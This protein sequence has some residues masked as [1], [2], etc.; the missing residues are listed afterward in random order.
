ML[1]WKADKPGA[2]LT[3]CHIGW[4]TLQGFALQFLEL[5]DETNV[6]LVL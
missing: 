6:H 3:H 2:W 5:E 1:A 4:H